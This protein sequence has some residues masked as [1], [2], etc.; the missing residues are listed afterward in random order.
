MGVTMV[1]ESIALYFLLLVL[2]LALN[3]VFVAT[4]FSL[5][6]SRHSRIQELADEGN[7]AAR[8]VQDLQRDI[9]TSVSGTQLGITLSS[10]AIGWVGENSLKELVNFLLSFVQAGPVSLPSGISVVISFAILSTVHVVLAEQVPKFVALRLPERIILILAPPFRIY[11]RIAWPLIWT[12]NRSAELI[13][14]L[15]GI[16]KPPPDAHLVHSAEE[17]ELLIEASRK[18]GELDQRETDLLTNVLDMRDLTM[19]KVLIPIKRVDA[20]RNDL[21]LAELLAVVQ[22]TK[23]SRLPVYEG[24]IDNIVG[25]LYTRDLFDWWSS[26]IAQAKGDPGLWKKQVQ[27]FQVKKFVRKAYFVL[28]SAKAST[29]LDDLRKLKIQIAIVRDASGKA[30]GLVTMEDLIEELVGEI[31]DEYDK[32]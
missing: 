21:S 14:K 22:K 25:I 5:V 6:A 12:M 15:I 1:L 10:L 29:L 9:G 26:S 30:V 20:I 28:K 27:E 7:A 4:E 3:A 13:L 18:A 23:H 17:L 19:E 24:Q 2:F 11:C 16:P 8:T 32:Q 31:Y